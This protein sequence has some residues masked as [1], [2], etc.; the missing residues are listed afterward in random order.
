MFQSATYLISSW[1]LDPFFSFS[2]LNWCLK[3]PVLKKLKEK[4]QNLLDNCPPTLQSIKQTGPKEAFFSWKYTQTFTKMHLNFSLIFVFDWVGATYLPY[5][6]NFFFSP[7]GRHGL[8]GF[9]PFKVF[10]VFRSC[11]N[12]SFYVTEKYPLLLNIDQYKN[13]CYLQHIFGVGSS[14]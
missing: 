5:C 1:V 7:A 6:C 8:V 12:A 2:F 9:W 13:G 3:F 4:N 10:S 11:T 14:L